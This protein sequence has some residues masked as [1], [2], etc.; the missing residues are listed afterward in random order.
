MAGDRAGLKIFLVA[1]D[2]VRFER[3]SKRDHLPLKKA[4]ETTLRRE[5]EE[6]ERFKSLYGIDIHDI[7]IYNLIMDTNL[8]PLI[9][10]KKTI[11]NITRDFIQYKKK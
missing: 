10:S 3:I 9:E 8:L 4:E 6:R 1:P 2:P 7:S 11:I 5:K